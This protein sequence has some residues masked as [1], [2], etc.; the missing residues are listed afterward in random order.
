MECLILYSLRC[1]PYLRS[2]SMKS[3][4]GGECRVEVLL[5]VLGTSQDYC[6]SGYAIDL[7]VKLATTVNFTYDLHLVEDNNYGS[8]E[9]VS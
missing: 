2:Y 6:C 7:L 1:F 5:S 4:R 8:L 9:R 3:T